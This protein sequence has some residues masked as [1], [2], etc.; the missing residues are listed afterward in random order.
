[1]V[2]PQEYG[3]IEQG[4]PRTARDAPL[5]YSSSATIIWRSNSMKLRLIALSALLALG[6]TANAKTFKWSSAG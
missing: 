4:K 2:Y 5:A 3:S 1:M 6:A